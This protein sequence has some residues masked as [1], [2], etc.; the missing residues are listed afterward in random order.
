MTI[1]ARKVGSQWLDP[2]EAADLA[3]CKRMYDNAALGFTYEACP[4]TDTE[5]DVLQH[6]AVDNGDGTA[7]NLT[8]VTA[9]I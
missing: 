5:G 1:F 2:R 4:Q 7:T 3:A 8:N 6:G 9:P